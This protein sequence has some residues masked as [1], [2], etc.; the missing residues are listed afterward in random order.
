MRTR[1][2]IYN[3]FSRDECDINTELTTSITSISW[4]LQGPQGIRT[5][6]VFRMSID[7]IHNVYK[8]Q[9][10]AGCWLIHPSPTSNVK[11]PKIFAPR[12]PVTGGVRVTSPPPR[13]WST[14]AGVSPS[15]WPCG[16]ASGRTGP[17]R[18][19]SRRS[20]WRMAW[21]QQPGDGGLGGQKARWLMVVNVMFNADW[22]WLIMVNNG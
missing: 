20:W 9:R 1:T 2:I 6:G 15:R 18:F 11:K 17:K 8:A 21:P 16:V 10:K 14:A 22:W 5:N 12:G 13:P 3:N 7:F 19:P 4:R